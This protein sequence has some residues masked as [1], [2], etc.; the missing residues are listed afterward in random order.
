MFAA[1]LGEMLAPVDLIN[2]CNKQIAICAFC[3]VP[4]I[5]PEIIVGLNKPM[6]CP[7]A[8]MRVGLGAIAHAVFGIALSAF[9]ITWPE[10]LPT[11][12][13]REIEFGI[14]HFQH[15]GMWKA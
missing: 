11:P 4:L 8:D 7:L 3:K 5:E 15:D 2:I 12:T 6:R 9:A 14:R 13:V 10:V 1:L